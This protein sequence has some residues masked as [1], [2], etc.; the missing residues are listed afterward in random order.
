MSIRNCII[1]GSG[2][3]GTSLAAGLLGQAGYFMGDELYPPDEGNPK[4][5]FEDREI[6]AINEGLLAELFPKPRKTLADRVW[7]RPRNRPRREWDRWLAE[8]KPGTRIHCPPKLV[9][10]IATATQ[11]EP[12]CFKD[13]RF[14]YTLPAWRRFVGGAVI[15]C[16]F[17]HPATTAASLMKEARRMRNLSQI[18]LKIDSD[19]ALRVWRLMYTHVLQVHHP[20]GGDWLFVHY[21][22]LV[23]GSAFPLIESHLGVSVDREFADLRLRRSEPAATVPA[24]VLALYRRLCELAGHDVG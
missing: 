12:F 24:D 10:R 4:G 19:L 8:I 1:L 5:Y 9:A 15:L 16:V 3:S 22:Q 6:N 23:D 18:K 20:A 17:R 13:P 7:G 21:D 11:H 14:C 2:R